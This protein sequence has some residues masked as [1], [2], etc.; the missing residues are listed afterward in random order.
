MVPSVYGVAPASSQLKQS[1]GVEPEH[2]AQLE[3]QA[4]HVLEAESLNISLGQS[5]THVALNKK[6]EL[7]D[8]Q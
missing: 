3:A 8:R 1:A 5:S 2:V 7:Q 4:A 6:V